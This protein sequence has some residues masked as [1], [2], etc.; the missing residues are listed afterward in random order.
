MQVYVGYLNLCTLCLAIG[1]GRCL[2][3]L[4]SE[5]VI[6]HRMLF[7]HRDS[8]CAIVEL[9]FIV[10]VLKAIVLFCADHFCMFSLLINDV[11]STMCCLLWQVE[12]GMQQVFSANISSVANVDAPLVS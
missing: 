10:L 8:L 9:L 12:S 2:W 1:H 7:F 4:I 6:H 3:N 11:C 5:D